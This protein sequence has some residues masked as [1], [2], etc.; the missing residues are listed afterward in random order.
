MFADKSVT[1]SVIQKNI[2]QVLDNDQYRRTLNKR[3]EDDSSSDESEV[4][5]DEDTGD[6]P[7]PKIRSM[8]TEE[9]KD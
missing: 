7:H 9:F 1:D 5:E 3:D 2:T 6:S 4:V 8:S